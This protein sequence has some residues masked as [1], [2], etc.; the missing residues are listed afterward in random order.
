[1]SLSKEYKAICDCC[2]RSGDGG[3]LLGGFRSSFT[4]TAG[5]DSVRPTVGQHEAPA[6]PV[7]AVAP[8]A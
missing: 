4:L 7:F 6:G 1:M 5:K 2:C 8:V 3:R